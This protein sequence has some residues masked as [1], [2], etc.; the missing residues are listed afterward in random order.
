MNMKT[1]MQITGYNVYYL[2][3]SFF[4]YTDHQID[5]VLGLVF[6]RRFSYSFSD[7]SVEQNPW[8]RPAEQ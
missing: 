2:L 1:G 7:S 6:V 8:R 3:G 4:R 5:R